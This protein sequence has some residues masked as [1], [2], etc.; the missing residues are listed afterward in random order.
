MPR[1]ITCP[2][3]SKREPPSP[4]YDPAER[5]LVVPLARPASLLPYG[6]VAH[7]HSSGWGA[8]MQMSADTLVFWTVLLAYV[9]MEVLR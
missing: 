3:S 5:H 9:V 6:L 1:W 7:W 4:S 2:E 8:G